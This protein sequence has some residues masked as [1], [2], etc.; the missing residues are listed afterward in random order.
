[1]VNPQQG[2][3]HICRVRNSGAGILPA[4]ET[5]KMPIGVKIKERRLQFQP[6]VTLPLPPPIEAG[7]QENPRPWRERAG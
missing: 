4:K 7:D 3:N 5:G 1:M 2:V 6:L